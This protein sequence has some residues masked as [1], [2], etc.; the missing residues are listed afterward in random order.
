MTNVSTRLA[1]CHQNAQLL[2]DVV[3][4]Q[5]C[6]NITFTGRTVLGQDS[7]LSG[8]WAASH[9]SQCEVALWS[10]PR[11]STDGR[12]LVC[13]IRMSPTGGGVTHLGSAHTALW[14]WMWRDAED[15]TK[16]ERASTIDVAIQAYGSAAVVDAYLAWYE[17][18]SW[19]GTVR[20]DP[21]WQYLVDRMR[22]DL[23]STDL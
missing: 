23:G 2:I 14:E 7:A 11:E 18:D 9:R 3:L 6:R 15:P 12:P 16:K 4:E 19:Q 10:P 21:R 20:E 1:G 17:D 22:Y 5:V 13:G 8:H